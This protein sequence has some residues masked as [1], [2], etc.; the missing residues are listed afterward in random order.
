MKIL[1]IFWLALI[2]SM[3]SSQ[4]VIVQGS[5]SIAHRAGTGAGSVRGVATLAPTS[6]NYCDGRFTIWSDNTNVV[7]AN[8]S[9]KTWTRNANILGHG[10]NWSAG[11]NWAAELDY[12]GYQDWRLPSSAEFTKESG[13]AGFLEVYPSTDNP[14]LPLGHPFINITTNDYYWTSSDSDPWMYYIS[15]WDGDQGMV[16][17]TNA[18]YLWPVRGP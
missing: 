13:S 8:D 9:G 14:A 2:G 3:V 16:I 4:S 18:Y 17:R 12:A 10:T 5:G 1:F 11:T 6:S 7:L 15:A